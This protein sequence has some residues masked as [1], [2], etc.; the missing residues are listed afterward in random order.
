M[1]TQPSG[2]DPTA[3]SPKQG[4]VTSDVFDKSF[5]S[6]EAPHI[7]T[8]LQESRPG[9]AGAAKAKAKIAQL[10]ERASAQ[11][12]Q[13][14]AKASELNSRA[15]AAYDRARASARNVQQ[16]VDPLVHERP[17]AAIGIAA[18]AGLFLG[19]LLGRGPKV[20]YLRPRD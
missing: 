14:S 12:D 16:R 19:L 8:P 1:P 4:G 9:R 18:C 13:A 6:P 20:I 15:A 2:S 5:A 7:E 10:A 11:V 17:Y 3:P